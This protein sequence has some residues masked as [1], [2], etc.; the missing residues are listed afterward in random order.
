ATA[1]V[2]LAFKKAWSSRLTDCTRMAGLVLP[3]SALATILDS[4]GLCTIDTVCGGIHMDRRAAS[5]MAI[6]AVAANK[7]RKNPLR[8]PKPAPD[9]N[10]QLLRLKPAPSH[11]RPHPALPLSWAHVRFWPLIL[12]G[13]GMDRN[14]RPVSRVAKGIRVGQ[15]R[16]D[17]W[18]PGGEPEKRCTFS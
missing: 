4:G 11:W 18:L 17:G 5:P 8:A 2:G 12:W 14:M 10:T 15:P 16:A 3:K 9:Q 13:K 1:S 6:A 7:L